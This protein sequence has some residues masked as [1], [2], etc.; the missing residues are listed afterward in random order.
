MNSLEYLKEEMRTK[1]DH[2]VS[3]KQLQHVYKKHVN[4]ST[5]DLRNRILYE[6]KRYASTF[7]GQEKDILSMIK[8]LILEDPYIAEDLRGMVLS[9]DPDPIFLQGELSHNVKGIWYGSNRVQRIYHMLWK[10]GKWWERMGYKK[11]L[12]CAKK[13]LSSFD[14]KYLMIRIT[15]SRIRKEKSFF[16]DFLLMIRQ[17]FTFDSKDRI[18]KSTLGSDTVFWILFCDSSNILFV[19]YNI[20]YR[21]CFSSYGK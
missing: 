17:N 7:I 2:I 5:E 6:N 18:P 14:H 19:S 12:S 10:T 20:L 4:I 11:C 8:K 1:L 16:P 21:A 13:L 9:D 15:D 3:I